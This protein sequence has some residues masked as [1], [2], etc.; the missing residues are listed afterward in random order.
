MPTINIHKNYTPSELRDALMQS[1]ALDAEVATDAVVILCDIVATQAEQIRLLQEQ[2]AQSQG[3][4]STLRYKAGLTEV[5]EL[6]E[7]A[8]AERR[9]S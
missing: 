2:V 5:D 4:I 9:A 1:D 7:M 6:E 3:F 8:A